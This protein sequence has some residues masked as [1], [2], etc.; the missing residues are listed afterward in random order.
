MA[1]KWQT[2]S[3][4]VDYLKSVVGL[5]LVASYPN[6]KVEQNML[7]LVINVTQAMGV[8]NCLWKKLSCSCEP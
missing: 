8:Y 5:S 6:N 4:L 2:C 7:Y 3:D 1:R